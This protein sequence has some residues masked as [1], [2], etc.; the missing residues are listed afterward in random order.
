MVENLSPLRFLP[1]RALVIG[2]NHRSS[3]MILRDRLFVEEEAE[4]LILE[5]LK[6]AG[7]D[8]ALILSTCDRVEIQAFCEDDSIDGLDLVHR[9]IKILA[10]HGELEPSELDGQTYVY[11]DEQAVR[12]IFAVTSSLDSLII[13]EPQ[14]LGQVKA[15]H[16]ISKT[17]GMTASSLES[18]LQAAYATAKKVRNE[19]A[20]GER[21]VSI[22]AAATELAGDLHGDLKNC[23]VLLVGGGEMG[24]LIALNMLSTGLGKLVTTHPSERRAEESAKR[25]NCHTGAFEDISNL[26]I[27]ADI[28]LASLGRRRYAISAEIVNSAITARRH[29]PVFLIDTAVPGDIDPLVERIEDAFLYGIDDLELVAMEGRA[30]RE[31]ESNAAWKIVDEEVDTFIRGHTERTAVPALNRLRS[32]FDAMREQ[33][34]AD[35]G[36]DPE[37]VTRLLINR[38]LHAPSAALRKLAADSDDWRYMENNLN[39]LFGLDDDE[40]N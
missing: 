34:L 39:R 36:V 5:R 23:S 38:L 1:G 22:A 32:H 13:G 14:V 15:S 2:A 28:V 4:P 26:L 30:G 29:K 3:S 24:E 6:E 35:G 20:I 16:R 40:K 33:A 9:I 17:V 25:L 37:K 27:D 18:I 10:Y 8:Q 21:P 12:Q 19:T 7:V 11:W 31:N